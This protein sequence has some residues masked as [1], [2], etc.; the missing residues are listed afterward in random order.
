MSKVACLSFDDPTVYNHKIDTLLRLKEYLPKLKVSFFMVPVDV[1]NEQVPA[2][3]MMLASNLKLIADNL[4]WIQ[5]IPHGLTHANREF[6]K[7]DREAMELAI[8]AIE[9]VFDG[10]KLPFERGFKAPQWLWNQDV[11]DVL[12]EHGWWGAVDRNQPKMARP[13]HTYTYTHSIHEPFWLDDTDTLCLHGH[14]SPPMDNDIDKC[15]TN[16][17][18]LPYNTEFKFVSDFVL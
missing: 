17:I 18:K 8:K 3:R 2:Q 6:E 12:S 13:K 5:L 14:Y 7:A 1:A 11:C 16:L 15:L 10:Y 9:N 4:D